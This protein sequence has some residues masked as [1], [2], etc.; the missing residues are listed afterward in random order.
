MGSAGTPGM[1]TDNSEIS[2][3]NN[4][5]YVVHGRACGAADRDGVSQ[6]GSNK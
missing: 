6:N 5:K 4:L 3:L 2:R 1:I